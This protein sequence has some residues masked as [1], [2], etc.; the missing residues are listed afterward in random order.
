MA[1]NNKEK[2]LELRAKG[3]SNAKIAELLLKN[4]EASPLAPVEKD[5]ELA[6]AKDIMVTEDDMP[7]DEASLS[8]GHISSSDTVLMQPALTGQAEQE[9]P[10]LH[11]QPQRV[12]WTC[13]CGVQLSDHYTEIVP[14]SLEQL[15]QRLRQGNSSPS[16]SRHNFWNSLVAWTTLRPSTA[17]RNSEYQSNTASH[18]QTAQAAQANSESNGKSVPGNA[19][20]GSA[21]RAPPLSGSTDTSNTLQSPQTHPAVSYLL[22]CTNREREI[23][24]A[25]AIQT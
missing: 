9:K 3:R 24:V 20:P 14:G 10:L 5:L 12:I 18:T 23:S 4:A 7:K 22:L 13:S 11:N 25:R 15:Q 17:H 2:V 16:R 1:G 8:N 6:L 19:G 21:A